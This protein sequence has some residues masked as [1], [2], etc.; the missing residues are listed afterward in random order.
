M[1]MARD[2]YATNASRSYGHIDAMREDM[3]ELDE[4]I[5]GRTETRMTS[6]GIKSVEW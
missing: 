2:E 5:E 1:K 3:G 6:I 4:N